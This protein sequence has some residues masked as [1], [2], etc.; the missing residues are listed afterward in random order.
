[1]V[2]N[3]T[4][5]RST[6]CLGAVIICDVLKVCPSQ[7]QLSTPL[8][9][10]VAMNVSRRHT[11]GMNMGSSTNS[12]TIYYIASELMFG[13]GWLWVHRDRS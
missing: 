4:A 11:G 7:Y 6:T 12:S 13:C 8:L 1:M 10:N 9:V 2:T 5:Q 3:P